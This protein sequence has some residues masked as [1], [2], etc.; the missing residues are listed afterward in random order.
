MRRYPISSFLFW[1][2]PKEARDDIEAY[3]FLSSVREWGNRAQHVRVPGDQELI[4]VLDGQQRLTSLYVGLQGTYNDRRTK[5]GKGSKTYVEKKLFLNLLHDGRVP[6]PN[7]WQKHYDFKFFDHIPVLERNAYWFETGRILR[8]SSEAAMKELLDRQ[9]KAIKDIRPLTQ[10]Q[11][12][13]VEHNLK[14]L[15]EVV[16]VDQAISYHTETDPDPERILEIFVRANSAGTILGKSDLLLST[17]TLHWGTEN[18]REEINGFLEEL[19]TKLTLKNR[20]KTDF[21]MKSCLVLLD[22]PVAY[23]VSSFTKATCTIIKERWTD[24]RDAIRQ[25]VDAA[26]AFGID[27]TTLTSANALIPLAYYLFRH[28]ELTLR[29]ESAK[30]AINSK[31]A[32]AWLIT[33]LLN[34]VLGGSSDSMLTKLREVLQ[35]HSHDGDFPLAELDRAVR[36]AG[37]IG[38]S[39]EDAI[40]NVLSLAYGDGACFLALSLLYEDRN[41]G[42]IPHSID[43]LFSQDMFKSMPS[44]IKE[45]RHDFANLALIKAD[46]NSAKQH[47]SL[48]EWLPSR[49]VQFLKRHLIPEDRLLWDIGRYEDFLIER[50]KLIRARL[51]NVL[52]TV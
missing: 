26:N 15:Y 28:P 22:L 52:S 31:R 3:R 42:T 41:W 50:Q 9:I 18:A 39:S 21:I 23:Q 40:E 2:V 19:N 27:E 49:N 12:E 36:E 51:E 8:V 11:V 25:A 7:N 48:V 16:W 6:D 45:H 43:H 44:G 30:E 47:Q 38:A 5:S 10:Q 1:Q 33:A 4:F 29:G 35:K 20:L 13:I 34:G 46:E 14:R 17:L 37:R 32:R 24:I